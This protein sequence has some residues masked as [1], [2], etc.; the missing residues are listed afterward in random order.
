MFSGSAS[1]SF[2]AAD[3]HAY[4]AVDIGGGVNAVVFM[5]IS[6]LR[7]DA[8]GEVLHYGDAGHFVQYFSGVSFCLHGEH[9]PVKPVVQRQIVGIGTQKCRWRKWVGVLNDG[10]TRS[11]RGLSPALK[12]GPVGFFRAHMLCVT[13]VHTSSGYF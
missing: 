10:I 5:Y 2:S 1:K 4:A 3:D 11:P 9:P 7:R 13:S 12:C 8:A 6:K